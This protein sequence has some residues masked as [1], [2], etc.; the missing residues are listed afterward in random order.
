MVRRATAV[1]IK[2][3]K[4]PNLSPH[5]FLPSLISFFGIDYK[6]SDFFL[7]LL[8]IVELLQHKDIGFLRISKIFQ[9]KLAFY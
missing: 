3:V 2:F 7:L 9:Y 8:C 1:R 5:G 4:I 6:A